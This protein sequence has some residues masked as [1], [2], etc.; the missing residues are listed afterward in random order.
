MSRRDRIDLE[1]NQNYSLEILR[2]EFLESKEKISKISSSV[3]S[4][5]SLIK[6]FIS[7]FSTRLEEISN[8]PNQ[9]STDSLEL[10][11]ITVI[12]TD[13][14]TNYGK[15][16][17]SIDKKINLLN[18]QVRSSENSESIELSSVKN[19]ILE[20]SD[21]MSKIH[22]TYKKVVGVISEIRESYLK[23]QQ[24]D[25]T[26]YVDGKFSLMKEELSLLLENSILQ[27]RRDN[28]STINDAVIKTIDSTLKPI[29]DS[30]FNSNI[31]SRKVADRLNHCE[32][33]INELSSSISD[34]IQRQ[35]NDGRIA[36]MENLSQ[37]DDSRNSMKT[38]I[39]NY[40]AVR[41]EL[42]RNEQENTRKISQVKENIERVEKF[43][44]NLSSKK[45]EHSHGKSEHSHSSRE[46]VTSSLIENLVERLNSHD[47]TINR[48]DNTICI[49][50]NEIASLKLKYET[51]RDNFKLFE[52]E[53]KSR[54]INESGRI[55]NLSSV[56][57][58]IRHEFSEIKND[59][60]TIGETLVKCSNK[61]SQINEDFSSKISGI[62]LRTSTLEQKMTSR[63][64]EIAEINNSLREIRLRISENVETKH[65][66]EKDE[67]VFN[68]YLRRI[69][70]L[71]H[72]LE[73]NELKDQ[74]L[75]EKLKDVPSLLTISE[76][77][78]K[79]LS[80]ANSSDRIPLIDEQVEKMENRLCLLGEEL[81]KNEKQFSILNKLNREFPILENKFQEF[82]QR[83]DRMEN[84]LPILDRRL[85]K[86][87]EEDIPKILSTQ[88]QE[89]DQRMDRMENQL[90]IFDRRLDKIYEEEIP[91]ILEKI[92]CNNS[93][94]KSHHLFEEELKMIESKISHQELAIS[95]INSELSNSK[96]CKNQ[97]LELDTIM[98][99]L[100][101]LECTLG[102]PDEKKPDRK[103]DVYSFSNRD[104]STKLAIVPGYDC[105]KERRGNC[106]SIFSGEG[107]N[108]VM[109]NDLELKRIKGENIETSNLTTTLINGIS[110][111]FLFL[112]RGS[113]SLEVNA[114]EV[115]TVNVTGEVNSI[116]VFYDDWCLPISDSTFTWRRTNEGFQIKC[117]EDSIAIVRGTKIRSGT[118]K[119]K[120]F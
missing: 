56:F 23:I 66:D 94:P 120:W 42:Q 72:Q 33:K 4:L 116:N 31:E 76:I 103:E 118:Y 68:D 39:K 85:D 52:A 115:F 15:K 44:E 110:S 69:Q 27:I 102:K 104:G 14:Q 63:I 107:K 25:G 17:E 78:K 62:S 70:K 113:T 45:I 29:T 93:L 101:S 119:I 47:I 55:D 48:H 38:I 112:N 61:I 9:N 59:N 99:R 51:S 22:E 65:C 105:I 24:N 43:L 54:Q 67:N 34:V 12:L 60:E 109:K 36:T 7:S 37:E 84:Q 74:V 79:I 46:N 16:I 49:N 5:S 114:G 19:R 41:E 106:V 53:V 30:I 86:I 11:N 8:Q 80:L 90:P 6:N 3:N 40:S 21:Q 77:E 95:R 10:Q 83:M 57:S 87:Y 2:S 13:L 32:S 75:S 96:E 64:E 71:E 18:S 73:T 88:F 81:D 35:K 50:S 26:R 58:D 92:E 111:K 91:K 1:N 100:N 98:D 89:F 82:D 117:S 97:N 20:I 28:V 108:I